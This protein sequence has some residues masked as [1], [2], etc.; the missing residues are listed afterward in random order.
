[1]S[2]IESEYRKC[3]ICKQDMYIQDEHRTNLGLPMDSHLDCLL[4]K[5]KL[6]QVK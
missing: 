2:I 5:P 1:M 3:S 4:K 6:E